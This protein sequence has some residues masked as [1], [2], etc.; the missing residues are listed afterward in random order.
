M[1]GRPL[2]K[3]GERYVYFTV[4]IP[5]GISWNPIPGPDYVA[6]GAY[7]GQFKIQKGEAERY[8]PEPQTGSKYS[9]LKMKKTDFDK[10]LRLALKNKK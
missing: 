10:K 5:T 8:D 3:I 1:D 6:V 7:Q 9:S 2:T 4:K